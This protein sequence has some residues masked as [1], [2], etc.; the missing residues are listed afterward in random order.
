MRTKKNVRKTLPNSLA[1]AFN[2][3]SERLINTKLMPR[4][5]SYKQKTHLQVQRG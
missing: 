1:V 4:S 2:L 3:S 5:A